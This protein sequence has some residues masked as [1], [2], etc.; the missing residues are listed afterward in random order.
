MKFGVSCTSLR[1]DLGA[2]REIAVAADELGFESLWLNGGRFVYPSDLEENLTTVGEVKVDGTTW[3]H[4]MLE[5]PPQS[6]D[7]Q[8]DNFVYFAH[9]A[10]LTTRI[11]FG[12][13]VYVV[14]VRHP[15]V[16]A[17]SV[18]TLDIVSGGRLLF[19]VGVGWLPAEFETVGWDFASR[20]RRADEAIEVCQKL[21][22]QDVVEHHGEFYDF[23]PVSFDPKPIQKPWPPIH[24]GGESVRA[25]RRAARH[26]G[27]LG[28]R[29]TPDEVRPV[30]ERFAE[31][32]GEEV[33]SRSFEVTVSAHD[34]AAGD[35][36][37]WEDAGVARLL[38]TPWDPD[39]DP[40]AGLE[41]F[42]REVHG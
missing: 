42:W 3:D 9:L 30:I 1:H 2:V 24:V 7:A 15:F 39:Q 21:W 29:T 26:D 18:Q 5:R 38:V 40:V 4:S 37:A 20:G 31:L 33:L 14:S 27:W 41:R 25:L 23:G 16:T 36:S 32:R 35:V 19:G 13:C 17:R 28:R 6:R 12:H 11:R 8:F 34:A 10:A 22:S